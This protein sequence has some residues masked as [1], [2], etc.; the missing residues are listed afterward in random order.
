MFGDRTSGAYLHRFAWTG[1]VRHQIVPGTASPND[2]ALTDY[3][4]KRRRT[5]P[6]PISST[7]LR[8]YQAQN[9]RCPICKTALLHVGQQPSTPKDWERWLATARD[10]ITIAVVGAATDE[11]DHRLLHANCHYGTQPAPP[12]PEPTRP[13]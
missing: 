11:P 8:L 5:A 7:S 6:L 1:I 2:P 9:G 4:T 10:T 12:A 3:W 13:A